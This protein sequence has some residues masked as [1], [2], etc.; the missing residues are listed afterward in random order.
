MGLGKT[1]QVLT[2]IDYFKE[3]IGF[4][5]EKVLIVMRVLADIIISLNI[6]HVLI[7]LKKLS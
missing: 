2:A 3:E 1:L 6:F 4:E 7:F 5:K